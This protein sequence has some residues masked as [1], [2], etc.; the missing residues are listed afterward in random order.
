MFGVKMYCRCLQMMLLFG[1]VLAFTKA[2][3]ELPAPAIW[4]EP[5]AQGLGLMLA[6]GSVMVFDG[7]L[8]PLESDWKSEW[9]LACE[10]QLLGIN[11][12]GRLAIAGADVVGPLLALHSRPACLSGTVLALAPEGK[13]LLKLNAR[14][15]LVTQV[16]LQAL[17][18]AELVLADLNAEGLPLLLVLSDPTERYAH[19]VLGDRLEAASLSVYTLDLEL[20]D[21]YELASHYVFEQRR[22][23]PL[24][25]ER[26]GVLATRSSAQTGAG[27]IFLEWQNNALALSAQAPAIG[28]GNRWL[29]L[30][31]SHKDMAFAIRTPHIGGPLQRYR[32]TQDALDIEAFD[33]GVTNHIIAARNLDLAIVLQANEQRQSLAAVSQD[34]HHV[35]FII[36]SSLCEATD[37]KELTGRLSSNLALISLAGQSLLAAADS[38]ARL[39]LWAY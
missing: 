37:R 10:G 4:L 16:G 32:L 35:Q 39:W 31:A 21:H 9:L 13:T 5:L 30:F 24:L 19:G 8:K 38:Q 18:D 33:L 11:Q 22:V 3:V 12:E 29:N 28:L 23:T 17:P 34:L 7:D 20:L 25:A 36:C 14:L 15:E 27:V 26:R 2:Q 1:F 6:D